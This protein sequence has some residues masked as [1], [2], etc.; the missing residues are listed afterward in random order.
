[1]DKETTN[2]GV[3]PRVVLVRLNECHLPGTEKSYR[4]TIPN[5]QMID[6]EEL[7]NRLTESGC[8][9]RK[10]SLILAYRLMT[11]EIYKA[12][13]DGFNV[14]IGLGKMELVVNGRFDSKYDK[15]PDHDPTKCL[16]SNFR[17]S[18]RLRQT[19]ENIPIR[20]TNF[21]PNA[22]RPGSISP[23]EE[24]NYEQGFYNTL[25]EGHNYAV[26]IHGYLMKLMGDLPGVGL[27][28]R[29]MDTSETYTWHAD[30]LLINQSTLL[31]F[32]PMQPFTV[33]RWEVEIATQ[34]NRSYRLYRKLRRG[35]FTFTVH[36]RNTL[37]D[38]TVQQ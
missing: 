27:T 20:I 17:P 19:A 35:S 2:K 29:N 3:T 26:F 21:F 24:E 9:M 1:M 25:P 31:C 38:D 30:D 6:I 10:E 4:A 11:S 8:S 33:G 16:S 15:A 7:A 34:Y 36:P 28:V 12:I 22:P 5:R 23:K 37:P 32:Q 14:D 18:P 13:E